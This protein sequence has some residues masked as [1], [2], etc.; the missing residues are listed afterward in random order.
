MRSVAQ[1]ED[2]AVPPPVG[3]L[4]AEG[5]LGTAQQLEVVGVDGA[6]PRREQG[7]QRREVGVG[8]G[9]LAGPQ[10]ELPP[11]AVLSDPH[12][13]GR[14]LRIADLVDAVPVPQVGRGADV[15]HQPLLT[16]REVHHVGADAL[17]DPAPRAVAAEDEVGGNRLLPP[18]GHVGERDGGAGRARGHV[19]HLDA[20][21]Q[22]DL[23]VVG[24]AGAQQLL[25]LRLVEHVGLG[26]PVHP[27]GPVAPELGER[28]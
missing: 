18:G 8:G 20:A 2:R 10:A 23:G 17:P 5:V 28:P 12:E 24:E 19:G 14:A 27:G 3:D 11:V 22:R 4:R 13:R 26:I 7:T 6:Q 1:E 15:D 25:Q 21:A 16:G 9:C